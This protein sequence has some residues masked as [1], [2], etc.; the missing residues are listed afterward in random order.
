LVFPEKTRELSV[1]V[2]LVAEM[3]VFIPLIFS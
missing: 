1:E 2:D 3:A